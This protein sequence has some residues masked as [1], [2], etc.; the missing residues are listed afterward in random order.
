MIARLAIPYRRPDISR[1]EFQTYWP[2]N[3]AP[4]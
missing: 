3:G 1:D 4:T 2:E